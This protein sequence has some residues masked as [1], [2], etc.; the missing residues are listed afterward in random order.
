M[1][2]KLRGSD[3]RIGLRWF[4]HA[5][6]AI[7]LM[8]K[9]HWKLHSPHRGAGSLLL[10][11]QTDLPLLHI[12]TNLHCSLQ[13]NKGEKLLLTV[14]SNS[15]LLAPCFLQK[16]ERV[17][18]SGSSGGCLKPQY[19][20]GAPGGTSV[21][22]LQLGQHPSTSLIVPERKYL[23]LVFGALIQKSFKSAVMS[24]WGRLTLLITIISFVNP[25]TVN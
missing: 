14:Q 11:S 7:S 2:L 13:Q 22:V 18:I 4:N 17:D 10:M 25:C 23:L 9:I 21:Q 1:L 5:S 12:M 16:P 6:R 15:V 20:T 3:R 24:L 19:W 8:G